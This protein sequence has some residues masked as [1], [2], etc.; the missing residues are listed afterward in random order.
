MYLI[1]VSGGPDS[2]FLLNLFKK[3]PIVVAHVNYHKREDS[4]VDEQIVRDFCQANNIPL[5]VLNVSEKAT[6]N[7]Q[8]WAREVRYNFFKQVYE[9]YE[10]DKLLMAHHKDDFIETALM[11]QRSGRVPRFFGIKEKNYLNDM[12]IERPLVDWYFKSEIVSYLDKQGIKY[13]LDYT[14]D[15]PIYERNKIRLELKDRTLREKQDLF[16][17]FVMS[18]KILKKKFKR[19]DY[20]LKKWEKSEWDC[21]LFNSLKFDKEEIIFEF[22]HANFDSVKLSSAKMKGLIQFIEGTEGGKSFVLNKDNKVSKIKGKL[23]IEK[24]VA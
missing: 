3:K 18:N 12:F 19:V 4:N 2:M 15:E 21:K 6:G 20:A 13:A 9:K 23:I 22:V 24:N 17:W 11:Q 5:E 1:A 14:N 8:A 16:K 7:F 10:C